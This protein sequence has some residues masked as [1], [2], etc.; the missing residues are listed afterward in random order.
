MEKPSRALIIDKIPKTDISPQV[1]KN[2]IGKDGRVSPREMDTFT[3]KNRHNDNSFAVLSV[4][5]IS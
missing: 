5:I 4:Y 3:S 2:H 1:Q